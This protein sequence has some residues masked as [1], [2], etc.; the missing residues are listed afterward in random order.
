MVKVVFHPD[1]VI[2]T[3]TEVES[4]VPPYLG[5]NDVKILNHLEDP[6]E[7]YTGLC[8]KWM[9]FVLHQD[10]INVFREI[11]GLTKE[12]KLTHHFKAFGV[13]NERK[14]HVFCIYCSDYS[15]ISFVRK[16][17]NVLLSEGLLAKYGYPYKDGTKALFFKTNSAT[18]HKSRSIGQFLTLFK[19]T[20]KKELFV[21][22]FQNKKP[23][24]KLVTND[25]DSSIIS[26]FEM[27]LATLK[28]K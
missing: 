16:I 24:W 18:E 25:K 20:D 6:D 22:E 10:F 2:Q 15:N 23:K 12:M 26:N 7:S 14:K 4:F 3:D 13:P 1:S 8:G 21:K 11:A 9:L 27:Y 5:W 17:A 28:N 19:F